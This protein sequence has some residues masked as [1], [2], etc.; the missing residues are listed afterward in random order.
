[1]DFPDDYIADLYR[2]NIHYFETQ[3]VPGEFE[4]LGGPKGA[5]LH[6]IHIFLDQW[7]NKEIKNKWRVQIPEMT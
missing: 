1:M 7:G 3:S 5:V 6:N 2:R 4:H